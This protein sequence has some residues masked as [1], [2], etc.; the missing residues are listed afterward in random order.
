MDVVCHPKHAFP[1]MYG[2]KTL[3]AYD[4]QFPDI[5]G[6][7]TTPVKAYTRLAE[8]LEAAAKASPR[9]AEMIGIAN[10]I[11]TRLMYAI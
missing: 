1:T 2:Q 10:E 4:L 8:Q 3:V 11:R 7:G 9:S 6:F 5:H